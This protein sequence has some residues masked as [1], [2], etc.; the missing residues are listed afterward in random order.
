MARRMTFRVSELK[1][2]VNGMLAKDTLDQKAKASL[3]SL[4]EDVLM[5][6]D[7]YRGFNDIYWMDK[8]FDEWK[9]AG[10]PDFPEKQKFMGLEYNRHYF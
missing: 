3:C 1:D 2:K 6:T 9:A 10:E 5:E 4:I 8:G 7:N